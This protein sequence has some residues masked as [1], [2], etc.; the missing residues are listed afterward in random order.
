MNIKNE[1]YGQA[2]Y[3]LYQVSLAVDNIECIATAIDERN[4]G[5]D[6]FA[7]NAMHFTANYMKDELEKARELLFRGYQNHSDA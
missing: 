7:A 1:N 4:G 2:D 3:S 6:S 5:K